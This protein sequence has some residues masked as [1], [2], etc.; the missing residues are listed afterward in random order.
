M[1][2][3]TRT[4]IDETISWYIAAMRA[5]WKE[6]EPNFCDVIALTRGWLPLKCGETMVIHYDD[7]EY[8]ITRKK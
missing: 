7:K 5:C 4:L 1:S 3:G 2:I 8:V 6:V